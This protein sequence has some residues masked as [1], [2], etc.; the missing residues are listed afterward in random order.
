MGFIAK[1]LIPNHNSTEEFNRQEALGRHLLMGC[2]QGNEF[3]HV[4]SGFALYELVYASGRTVE[5]RRGEQA[6]AQC[7]NDHL[8]CF[9]TMSLKANLLLKGIKFL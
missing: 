7:C 5:L 6:S 3:P 4:G 9:L 1:T 8:D 2:G